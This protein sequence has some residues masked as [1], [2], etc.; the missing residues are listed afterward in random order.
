MTLEGILV[1]VRHGDRGPLAHVRNITTVNCGKDFIGSGLMDNVYTSYKNYIENA[2]TNSRGLW[3]Q[4]LGPFHGFPMLPT[5][6]RDCKLAQLTGLGVSQLLKTGLILRGAYLN[7]LGISNGTLGAN[8]VLV[9]STRYRR[10][11]QSVVAL[12]YGFLETDYGLTNLGKISLQESQSL[13]FCNADCACP[14]ADKFGKQHSKESAE[15]LRSHPA[16]AGLI[17]QAANVVFE[18]PDQALT[19]DPNSLRDALLTYVCHNAPLPCID[20]DK[21]QQ[22]CVKTEHVT[23]LFAY[24]EWEAKQRAKSRSQRRYGLLRAY[25]LLRNVVSHMLRII[26]EARPK[27]V[28]YS[29]HDKTL[30]YL[31]T[32]FGLIADRLSMSH[33]ASRFVLEI[34]KMNPKN[35]NH[36]ASDFYF[37]VVVNGKDLTRD[38]TFCKNSLSFYMGGDNGNN[39][40]N[41]NQASD[42]FDKTD[43][44]YF[45][46]KIH[47]YDPIYYHKLCPIE[48]IIRQLHDDYFSPFNA[49]N[50]KDACSIRK[51]G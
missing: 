31:A 8:D 18:M 28:I 26:S 17:R 20:I 37:R 47:K 5:N 4:F 38:V 35:E 19:S 16:V 33:Y 13:A 6:S 42:S 15:H 45:Q 21:S 36:V 32:A 12:L 46:D 48:A 43:T 10:T 3:S 27:I 39:N 30:E 25:G 22:F 41:I 29:G 2:S 7:R 1:F 34:Y 50:F 40:V 51:H 44:N 49:T 11:V 23:S 9:Y 24:T 14:A